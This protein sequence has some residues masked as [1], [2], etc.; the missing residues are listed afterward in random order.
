MII[1]IQ[2]KPKVVLGPD[3]VVFHKVFGEKN[4]KVSKLIR[5]LLLCVLKI[6]FL[7]QRHEWCYTHCKILPL[8]LVSISE[9]MVQTSHI[10]RVPSY[11]CVCRYN[12]IHTEYGI[13][14]LEALEHISQS[15]KKNR[16]EQEIN[17][18]CCMILHG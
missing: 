3:R 11:P 4:G 7:L 13:G 14:C 18:F 17:V 8:E 10:G 1:M 6:V 16:P 15:S 2:R 5:F 12:Q 9:T